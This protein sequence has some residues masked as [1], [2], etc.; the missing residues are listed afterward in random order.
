MENLWGGC[1]FGRP[2]AKVGDNRRLLVNWIL[3]LSPPIA[4]SHLRYNGRKP[5]FIFRIEHFLQFGMSND[6]S[7]LD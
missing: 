4:V 1:E 6:E 7:Y 2:E 5:S 3:F